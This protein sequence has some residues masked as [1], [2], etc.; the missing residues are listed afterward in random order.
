MISFKT[1][2]DQIFYSEREN[3]FFLKELSELYL[4]LKLQPLIYVSCALLCVTIHFYNYCGA[5]STNFG[6]EEVT[7]D[8]ETLAVCQESRI[9]PF[10]L[11]QEINVSTEFS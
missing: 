2:L 10:R 11:S 3:C 1:G 4:R 9:G 5:Q 7:L 8:H 6:S